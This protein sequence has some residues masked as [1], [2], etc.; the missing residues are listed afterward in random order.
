MVSDPTKR[1]TFQKGLEDH[2]PQPHLQLNAARYDIFGAMGDG[3]RDIVKARHAWSDRPVPMQLSATKGD[4]DKSKSEK[5]KFQDDKHEDAEG[6]DTAMGVDKGGQRCFYC[7]QHMH[8]KAD[9]RKKA[10]A[11]SQSGR[12]HDDGIPTLEQLDQ[13]EDTVE[14]YLTGMVLCDSRAA[15]DIFLPGS[16]PHSSTTQ[17]QGHDRFESVTGKELQHSGEKPTMYNTAAGRMQSTYLGTS[18]NDQ[19]RSVSQMDDHGATQL[20]APMA[21]TWYEARIRSR[22]PEDPSIRP[23]VEHVRGAGGP[24]GALR[25][26]GA[27]RPHDSGGGR[28]SGGSR[29]GPDG[30]RNNSESMSALT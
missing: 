28:D 27:V 9:Y 21:T 23:G 10:T 26:R 11:Q 12:L 8:T 17:P 3:I 7:D 18:V 4:F 5:G 1:G 30:D 20:F 6:H 13:Y 25:R 22:R 19:V 14:Q 2:D 15:R 16:A 24:R 29:A